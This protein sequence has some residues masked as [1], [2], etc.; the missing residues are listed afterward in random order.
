MISPDA[1]TCTGRRRMCDIVL[2]ADAWKP[3]LERVPQCWRGGGRD[4]LLI[5]RRLRT[6]SFLFYCFVVF[7]CFLVVVFCGCRCDD[8]IWDGRFWIVGM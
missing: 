5:V 6:A 8:G 1:P 7:S 3:Y 2:D 4:F